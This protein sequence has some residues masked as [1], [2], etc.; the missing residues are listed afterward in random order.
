[1][2]HFGDWQVQAV[3]RVKICGLRRP[4]DVL[5]V[6]EAEPDYV[7]F[8]FAPKSH[9]Y[10]TLEQAKELRAILKPTIIPIGVFVNADIDTV[11][12]HVTE[13]AIDIVQLHG[14]EDE[15]Y[16]HSLRMRLPE[17][18]II[19][20]IRVRNEADVMAGRI[21]DADYLLFD[22]CCA[23]KDG[24]TGQCFNWGLLNGVTEPFFLAGGLDPE[25]VRMAID[26]V[27][28]Y[29]VDVSS[30]VETDGYKDR[31]KIRSLIEQVRKS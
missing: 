6:N 5:Y 23:D 15:A 27:K 26:T 24:G 14:N 9:R 4:E 21:V 18:E 22:A 28:P 8:I 10:I 19:R 11:V 3:T 13:G 7:G 16:I 1:M 30:G 17:T 20:A 2:K 29:A 31:N 25:N 12:R